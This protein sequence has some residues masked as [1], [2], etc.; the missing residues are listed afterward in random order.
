MYVS[1]H[2]RRGVAATTI[3]NLFHRTPKPNIPAMRKLDLKAFKISSTFWLDP[4]SAASAAS[5]IPA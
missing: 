1:I 3:I 5:P 4:R 2:D